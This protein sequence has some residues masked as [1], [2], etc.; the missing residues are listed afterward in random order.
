[1]ISGARGGSWLRRLRQV[2][3]EETEALSHG[4]WLAAALPRLIPAGAGGRLRASLYRGLGMQVGRES[5]IAGALTLG[6]APGGLRRIMLGR[7]CFVNSHVFI[8]A[9]SEVRIGN[10]VSIGH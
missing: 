1:M 6:A 9:A 3:R 7:R 2:W 10:G 5:T 8:D 4:A